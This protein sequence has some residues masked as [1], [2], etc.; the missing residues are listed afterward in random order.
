MTCP[1]C[2]KPIHAMTGLQEARKFHKHL[3]LC[4][5]APRN[6]VIREGR[7]SAVGAP[8]YSMHDALKIRGESG[9]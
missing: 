4:R 6:V 9:Q 5:K 3:P 1:Y 8:D 2:S 7:K